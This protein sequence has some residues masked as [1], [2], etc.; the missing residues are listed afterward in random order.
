[1]TQETL[2]HLEFREMREKMRLTQEELGNELG[3]SRRTIVRLENREI[4]I[5]RVTSLAMQK[6]YDDF[7][8]A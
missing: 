3:I 6:L 8:Y 7:L 2:T 4:D 1:M 5:S